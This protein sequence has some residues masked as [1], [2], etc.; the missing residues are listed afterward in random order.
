MEHARALAHPDRL[1]TRRARRHLDLE[2]LPRARTEPPRHLVVG[3]PVE[4][5]EETGVVLLR[6]PVLLLRRVLVA[7]CP[8]FLGEDAQGC[9]IGRRRHLREGSRLRGSQFDRC[10]VTGEA[11][12]YGVNAGSGAVRPR[13]GRLTTL[14]QGVRATRV[15][16]GDSSAERL[17]DPVH[18][19][20]RVPAGL[21]QDRGA[22]GFHLG[23]SVP[24]SDNL[25][26]DAEHH[27][28]CGRR[29]DEDAPAVGIREIVGDLGPHARCLR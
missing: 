16:V 10:D 19:S 22:P 15:P 9:E 14:R 17:S 25:C 23:E 29:P 6:V 24:P 1:R 28:E 2:P 12:R 27:S 21:P 13:Q 18:R 11:E 8:V 20:G 26:C 5:V 3:R 7:A 4:R